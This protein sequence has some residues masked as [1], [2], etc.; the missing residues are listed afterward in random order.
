LKANLIWSQLPEGVPVVQLRTDL[1]SQQQDKSRV[2]DPHQKNDDRSQRA[3]N[4]LVT[5]EVFDIKNKEISGDF[6]KNSGQDSPWPDKTPLRAG[7][8]DIFIKQ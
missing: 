8:R 1:G 7:V 4:K 5:G 3:V 6:K 2:V